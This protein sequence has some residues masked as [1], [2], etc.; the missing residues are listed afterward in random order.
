MDRESGR[1][2]SVSRQDRQEEARDKKSETAFFNLF[3][4]ISIF[5]K[6]AIAWMD[7]ICSSNLS[8]TYYRRNIKV[9]C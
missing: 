2:S 7:S 6:E 1:A 8:S 9:A 3:D 5:S 4:K